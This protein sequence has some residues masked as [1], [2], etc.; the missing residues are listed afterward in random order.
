M[1]WKDIVFYPSLSAFSFFFF[2]S[3]LQTYCGVLR[4]NA[5]RRV[6]VEAVA[7]R[8]RGLRVLA[9]EVIVNVE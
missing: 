7:A 8:T 5:G 4:M 2:F 3:M 6:R 1:W 9:M